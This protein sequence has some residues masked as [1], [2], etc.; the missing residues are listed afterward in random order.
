MNQSIECTKCKETK[1]TTE[2][3][4]RAHNSKRGFNSWCK[5]CNTTHNTAKRHDGF[6][7]V[8]YIVNEHYCGYTRNLERRITDHK[9]DGKDCSEVRL[10]YTSEDRVEAAHTEALFQSYLGMNGLSLTGWK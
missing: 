5:K 4:P 3:S 9:R 1:L 8:Y 6:Y 2:F 10:L 7:S